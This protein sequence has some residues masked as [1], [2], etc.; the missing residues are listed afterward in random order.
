MKVQTF[1]YSVDVLQAILWQYNDAVNLLS[2]LNQKQ[3]WYDDYQEKFWD[4]GS[5]TNHC[6][7][8]RETGLQVCAELPRGWRENVFDLADAGMFGIAVWSIILDVP[9]FVRA[10]V[11]PNT[12]IF[13][14]NEYVSGYSGPLINDY[15]NFDNGNFSNFNTQISL[16]EEEQRFLLRLRYFQLVTNGAIAN[17]ENGFGSIDANPIDINEFLY[18]LCATSNIDYD[19]TIFV[20]DNLNM[21]LTYVFT[22]LFPPALQQ[23]IQLL[24]MLPRPAGVQYL[25]EYRPETNYFYLL[26]EN[27]FLLLNGNNFSLL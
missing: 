7:I 1:D 14:F 16:T 25:W 12:M 4:S 2:I 9:L 26:N 27:P 18:Y 11:V 8:D 10:D 5:E 23:A 24:D 22:G 13:G 21:T 19:G 15:L 20:E 3:T 6:W 17:I